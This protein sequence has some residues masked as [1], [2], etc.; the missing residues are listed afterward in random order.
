MAARE[1]STFHLELHVYKRRNSLQS[2]GGVKQ[3]Q[4]WR[5]SST[6]VEGG[7][8]QG[9]VAA[10]QGGGAASISAEMS[11]VMQMFLEDRRRQDMELAE[12]HHKWDAELMRRDEDMERRDEYNKQLIEVLQSWV[13]GE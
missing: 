11:A 2:Y 9:G 7:G 10:H 8:A 4:F 13:Q 6:K 12:E 3:K 5:T 1:L